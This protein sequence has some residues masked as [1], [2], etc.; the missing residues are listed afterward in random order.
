VSFQA[1][2]I[3]LAFG[4]AMAL[5]S[6]VL[7]YAHVPPDAARAAAKGTAKSA[8]ISRRDLVI[9]LVL[10]A[11]LVPEVVHFG[12]YNQAF[13]IFPVW[14]TDNVQR[15]ILGVE[16]PVTWF[17]TLDGLLTIAGVMM[18][19]RLWDRQAR[20]GR[21]MGDMARMA[22]GAAL[23]AIGFGILTLSAAVQGSGKV[24]FLAGA[25]FFLFVDFAIPWVDT[26]TMALVSRRAPAPINST[27]M[28]VYTLSV[29][30]GYFATGQLG[31]LYPHVSHP[32]FWGVHAAMGLACLAYLALAGPPIA[33][34]LN[35]TPTA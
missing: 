10:T 17:S 13:D 16:M 30:A 21:P 23:G 28:G 35:R 4:M 22:V 12:A 20:R 5:V 33:R 15:H 9:A 34:F 3:A 24:P 32:V 6:F 7:G 31:R 26:V 25:G 1:G 29:A 19:I 8:P 27:M 11:A 14:A 2:L 18:A